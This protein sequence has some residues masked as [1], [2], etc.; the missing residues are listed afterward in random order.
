MTHVTDKQLL[1]L[2]EFLA[3]PALI[4]GVSNRWLKYGPMRVYLRK[5]VRMFRRHFVGDNCYKSVTLKT[6][7]VATVSIDNKKQQKQ[8]VFKE[9]LSFLESGT[10]ASNYG[11]E[12][13]YVENMLDE[14]MAHF[15]MRRGYYI[16]STRL[17]PNAYHILIPNPNWQPNKTTLREALS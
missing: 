4:P 12:V 1:E 7:D 11:S 5:T 3:T 2:K 6:L 8:G 14:W 17:I 15:F 16:D 13:I 9:F 10:G